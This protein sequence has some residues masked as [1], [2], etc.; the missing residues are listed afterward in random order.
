[1]QTWLRIQA[2]KDANIGKEFPYSKSMACLS[3]SI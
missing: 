3:Y 2:D 1:M